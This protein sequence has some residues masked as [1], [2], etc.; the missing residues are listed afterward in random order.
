LAPRSE[1]AAEREG[2]PASAARSGLS[3]GIQALIVAA[4]GLAV[5]L[6]MRDQDWR[7]I[8]Q[9]ALATPRTKIIYASFIFFVS[10]VLQTARFYTLCP[11]GLS[12]RR[13]VGLNMG[14]QAG[15]I[16]LPFRAGELFRPVLMRKW[17]H[18]LRW[19]TILFWVLLEKI[20]EA[21]TLA[22]LLCV[23]IWYLG[24]MGSWRASAP[25]YTLGTALALALG[26]MFRRRVRAWVH[27]VSERE[28]FARFL[29]GPFVVSA[30]SWLAWWWLF[31]SF[32]PSPLLSLALSVAVIL[33]SSIPALPAGLGAFQAAFV[34]VATRF[35]V[36][37]S[38][39]MASSLV[40]HG[41]IILW[42]LVWG[43]PYLV[44]WGIPKRERIL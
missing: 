35:G 15:I 37:A 25:W 14:S 11:G 32:V 5:Y 17:N 29:V 4:V 41:I 19:K 10:R 38:Q 21:I 31:Y 42:T 6:T 27:E 8:G 16:L 22:P 3:R 26:W 12:F 24:G 43:V 28:R 7:A 39:A 9:A 30:L 2:N 18:E 44:A 13:H 20:I 34:W 40:L 23:A 1:G 33:S 36:P